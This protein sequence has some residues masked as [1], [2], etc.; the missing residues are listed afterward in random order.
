MHQLIRPLC[1]RSISSRP[2]YRYLS[3]RL[4]SA[5][6]AQTVSRIRE[7][8]QNLLPDAPF[9]SSFVDAQIEQQYATDQKMQDIVRV[10]AVLALAIACMG[11]FGLASI[12]AARRVKE[13]G[14]R[15][16]L[17]A[18]TSQAAIM[19]SREFLWW[20]FISNIIAFPI[21]W[22]ALHGWLEGFAYRVEIGWWVFAA[23]G[24]IS[25]LIALLTVSTQAIKAALANPV[26]SLRYE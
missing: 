18:S 20:V 12:S 8:W 21:A 14:V 17:G 26:K 24:G 4:S 23:A 7:T 10:A 11:M 1:F 6:A 16:V 25:L 19:L 13:I 3:L 15:K 22:Y 5:Q 9:E 2:Y